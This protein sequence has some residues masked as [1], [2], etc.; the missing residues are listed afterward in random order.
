MSLSTLAVEV[1]YGAAFSAAETSP[2]R[3]GFGVRGGVELTSRVWLGASLTSHVGSAIAANGPGNSYSFRAWDTYL[4]P[5]IGYVVHLG[6]FRVQP[7]LGAGLLAAHE[8]SDVRGV[9]ASSDRIHVYV[10]PGVLVGATWDGWIAGVDA[11]VPI[12]YA[13][14]FGDWAVGIF[15]LV[16]RSL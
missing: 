16:G 3:A 2:D 4:G 1:G 13:R 9:S 5:E 12:L 8:R 14:D 11:R 15:G 7:T 6:A 10:A